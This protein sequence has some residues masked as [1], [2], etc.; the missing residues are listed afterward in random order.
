MK[1]YPLWLVIALALLYASCHS[2]PK[3]PPAQRTVEYEVLQKHT[4]ASTDTMISIGRA[5]YEK[6]A[7]YIIN[8]GGTIVMGLG[9]NV[10][11]PKQYIFYDKAN[12]RHELTAVLKD[13]N[14]SNL[15]ATEIGVWVNTGASQGEG[16]MFYYV[17]YP[18]CIVL[19]KQY[20]KYLDKIE[21]AYTQLLTVATK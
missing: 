12:N 8:Q 17:I 4:I 16:P 13:N 14:T 3:S 15:V 20:V 7:G 1:N 6:I 9:V 10:P 18:D 2:H 19:Q 21:K 11:F 5:E